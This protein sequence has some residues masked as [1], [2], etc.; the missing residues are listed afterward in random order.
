MYENV[1]KNQSRLV[2]FKQNYLASVWSNSRC[3]G[4]GLAAQKSFIVIVKQLILL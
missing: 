1:F 4:K 3:Q 2:E